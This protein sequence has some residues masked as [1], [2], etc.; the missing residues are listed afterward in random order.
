MTTQA[1]LRATE[2]R[3]KALLKELDDVGSVGADL[4]PGDPLCLEA[5]AQTTSSSSRRNERV[6]WTFLTIKRVFELL[7]GGFAMADF[8]K[9]C[10]IT[11]FGKDYGDLCGYTAVDSTG[12]CIGDCLEHHGY[13]RTPNWIVYDPRHS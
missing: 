3:T 12:T 1:S 5:A 6:R 13:I 2:G 8:C 9:Q 11:N 4:S 10:S 7:K